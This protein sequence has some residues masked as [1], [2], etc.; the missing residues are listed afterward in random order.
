[1]ALA[2]P[3]I[4]L[5]PWCLLSSPSPPPVSPFVPPRPQGSSAEV[6]EAAAEGLGELVGSTS[7]EALRPFVVSITGGC[8]RG[9][10]G[11]KEEGWHEVVAA[12]GVT[13]EPQSAHARYRR[14]LALSSKGLH[15]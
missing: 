2:P 9:R 12:L 11:S 8:G 3:V 4:L 15:Y 13:A 7:E 10:G 1:M 5:R 14:T 6:R